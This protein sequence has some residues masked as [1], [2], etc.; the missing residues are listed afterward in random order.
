MV[1]SYLEFFLLVLASYRLTRLL[2]YDKITSFVRRPFIEEVEDDENDGST[3]IYIKIKGTGFRAWIGELLSCHW[4][5]GIWSS[6]IL[7]VLFMV[8]P[9]WT[10]PFILILAIA[11]FA[12][13]IESLINREV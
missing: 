2:V 9:L 5:T 1:N 4:C 13:V 7:Y 11:G 10:E 12:G 8:W 6:A 3:T